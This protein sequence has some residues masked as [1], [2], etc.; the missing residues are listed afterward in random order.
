MPHSPDSSQLARARFRV[1]TLLLEPDSRVATC[2]LLGF[3]LLLPAEPLYNLPFIALGILGFVQL[4]SRRTRLASPEFRF[5]CIAFLC[6]WLPMLASLPD[7]VNFVESLR[8]SASL[9]IYFLAGVYAV[10]AYKSLRELGWIVGGVAAICGFWVLDALW[11]F[12]T[13]ANWFGFSHSEGARLTGM[14]YTGR[15]GYLL[16]SFAPLVF[17]AIRRASQRWRW[18]PVLILPYL[19]TIVLAGSRSSWGAL[20]I[21]AAGY[22]IFLFCWSDRRSPAQGTKKLKGTVAAFAGLLLAVALA[23]YT[24]PGVVDRAWKTVHPRIQTLSGLWS[25]DRERIEQAVTYRVSIWETALN[26]WSEHWLNGVGPRGFQHAYRQFNPDVDYYLLRDGSYGAAKSPHM[27]LLEIGA[28][29]GLIGLLGYAIL[30][31][32][33]LATLRRL[34]RS[35]FVSVYPFALTLIVALF[36]FSG[37]LGFYGVFSV[38]VIWWMI[39][40]TA[41]ALA[42][43]SRREPANASGT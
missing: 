6:V 38:G 22:L 11:Q 21:A 42:I 25:G 37:H 18:C 5:L 28:E 30:V 33:L 12:Q 32:T 43:A 7:A 24:W 23:A 13:G 31:V 27:Q 16:A 9:C 17:E 35:A 10:G 2:L 39:I 29:T 41:S 1:P 19:A 14:F 20:A 8:K 15:I 3:V 34:E 36:P 26:M 40:V 4:V